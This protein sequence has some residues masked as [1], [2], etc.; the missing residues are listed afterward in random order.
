MPAL[1]RL[2]NWAGMLGSRVLLSSA[3]LPP[4]VVEALF[5]AYQAGREHFN[6]ACGEPGTSA[7]VCCAWFD[8]TLSPYTCQCA[9]PSE[10]TQSHWSFVTRRVAA[11]RKQPVLRKAAL[12]PVNVANSE[13]KEVVHGLAEAIETGMYS[14]HKNH[15]Q[16]HPE[17]GQCV[18][19]GVVR[20]ANIRPMVAVALRLLKQTPPEDYDIRFCI[21]HSRHPVIVRSAMEATLDKAL[22][23]HT[24]EALWDVSSIKT[25]LK[26]SPARHLL[27]VV[28]ATAVAEVGRDHD[29]DW[30]IAE[31][32]SMRSLIQ[33]AG[34]IQRHR[35]QIP[36]SNNML[37]LNSNYRAL[38]GQSPAYCW[39]GFESKKFPLSN[40]DLSKI[41][42]PEQY[43]EISA[44]ER[45]QPAQDLAPANNLADLEHAH[46]RECLFGEQGKIPAY[47]ARWW[48]PNLTWSA[49][50]Q[51]RTRF[52]EARS[53]EQFVLYSEDEN[54]KPLFYRLGEKGHIDKP[55]ECRFKHTAPT[56]GARVQPWCDLA[57]TPLLQELAAA[58]GMTFARTC[59]MFAGVRLPE[60]EEPWCYSPQFG[61]Y[62]A[63]S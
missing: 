50:L 28:F 21:Y 38:T 24:P 63:L 53:D 54:D 26:A 47:A 48:G 20:M 43:R 52:R 62:R 33:L 7:A 59:E 10:F 56:Y 35:C 2:V 22:D 27:F 23:R 15:H 51:K 61:I 4:S 13:P 9:Q 36:P 25:A 31:P 30:A 29:Y 45:I 37:I 32:S 40:T 17:T 60:A 19:I 11:L 16:Q 44:I 42:R 6:R 49:E 3:T 55:A 57:I 41:L 5:C 8:E 46:L 34:R 18:S 58:R 12:Q 14:L 1:C 39:P